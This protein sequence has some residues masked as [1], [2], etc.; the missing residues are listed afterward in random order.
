MTTRKPYPS[1]LTDAEFSLIE[2]LLPTRKSRKPSRGRPSKYSKREILNGIRYVVRS[3]CAWRLM[4]H[5]FPPWETVYGYFRKWKKDGTWFQIHETLRE[6]VRVAENRNPKPSA[7]ILDSQSVKTTE[8]RGERGYDSG[9]KINGRKRHL[10]VDVLGL[11][12]AVVVHTADIQDRDGAKLL[13]ESVKASFWRLRLIWADGA[14]AGSLLD[15]VAALRKR[16]KLRLEIVKR[17]KGVKGFQVLH[18]RWIVERTFAW[19][20]RHR[21]MSK[22]YEMLPHTSETMIRIVM[23]GFMLRRI[24]TK[25]VAASTAPTRATVPVSTSGR[26]GRLITSAGRR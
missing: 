1:D 20:G 13:L 5:D 3:G 8:V 19:L 10:L 26:N 4:P 2:S 11:V 24:A 12:I 18:H 7:G 14:Y 6:D 21:R 9:K 25:R 22:D 17:K 15:W 16:C 23:I